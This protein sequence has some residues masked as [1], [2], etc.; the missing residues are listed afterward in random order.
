MAIKSISKSK[1]R[2]VENGLM[3][4]VTEIR[5]HWAL[6]QCENILRLIM[7]F[8]DD[9]RI[10]LILEYQEQGSLLKKMMEVQ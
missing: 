6:E 7:M 2:E 4:I 1:L 5:V 8:E 3:N 10:F 9:D